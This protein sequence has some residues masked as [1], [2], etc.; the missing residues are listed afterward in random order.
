MRYSVRP[1]GSVCSQEIQFSLDNGIV[2]ALS[3]IGGCAGNLTGISRLVVGMSA[4]Q[5][6]ACL[7]G[8]QCRDRGT[9]CPD[10]IAKALRER[11]EEA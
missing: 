11:V 6:I 5:V 7:E 3:I 1:A 8:V 9:S 2:T 10:Q 4:K